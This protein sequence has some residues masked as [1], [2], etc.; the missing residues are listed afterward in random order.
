MSHLIDRDRSVNRRKNHEVIDGV[1]PRVHL[2][3]SN[4]RFEIKR[5]TST[6][7][8]ADRKAEIGVGEKD[9]VCYGIVQ[10]FYITVISRLIF[11]PE[12]VHVC[13]VIESL[14]EWKKSEH[15]RGIGR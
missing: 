4:L 15:V 5:K 13:R 6:Y 12:L 11:L 7:I 10:L 1:V 9:H 8:S 14:Q 2:S 3:G